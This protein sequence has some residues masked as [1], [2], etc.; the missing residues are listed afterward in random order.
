MNL[1]I[2]HQTSAP[3]A[4]KLKATYMTYLE[5]LKRADERRKLALRGG[6]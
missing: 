4:G 1:L 2:E 3:D 5:E 6:H